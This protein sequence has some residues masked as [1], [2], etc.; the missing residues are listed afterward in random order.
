[1]QR[2]DN[3][4]LESILLEILKVF[5]WRINLFS[6]SLAGKHI[7]SLTSI[8]AVLGHGTRHFCAWH[9][10]SVSYH[11]NGLFSAT[12]GQRW[13]ESKFF[14][15][16][17]SYVWFLRFSFNWRSICTTAAD[18]SA[19][20]IPYSTCDPNR[21]DWGRVIIS[22]TLWRK[23]NTVCLR[24]VILLLSESLFSLRTLKF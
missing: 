20:N 8:R 12:F 9:D 10:P 5:G 4:F 21:E 19:V 22:G 3:T 15:C 11:F 24:C 23:G 14:I 16:F 6:N 1:M 18:S 13:P 7:S 17:I 2:M